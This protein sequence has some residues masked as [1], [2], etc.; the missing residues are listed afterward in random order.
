MKRFL[1]VLV[2]ISLLI[3]LALLCAPAYYGVL[4]LAVPSARAEFLNHWALESE[5]LTDSEQA[6]LE[7]VDCF[8]PLNCRVTLG[9]DVYSIPL[10]PGATLFETARH[11]TRPGRAQYLVRTGPFEAWRD[12][13]VLTVPNGFTFERLGSML[14]F[15]SADGNV[16]MFITGYTCARVYTLLEVSAR[17]GT[18]ELIGLE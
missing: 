2:V 10:P 12:D 13:L 6:A 4:A 17:G 11:P 14:R 8:H 5:G 7:R 9:T 18:G 3:P 16:S 1:N 15:A